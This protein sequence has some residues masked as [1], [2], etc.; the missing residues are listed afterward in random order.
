MS[1]PAIDQHTLRRLAVEA[2]RDPRT[3]LAVLE[4]RGTALSRA[5]V[6]AAALR[7]GLGLGLGLEADAP[8][9]RATG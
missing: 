3:V 4:G 8:R 5:A 7:L 2:A 6:R 1:A 9:T